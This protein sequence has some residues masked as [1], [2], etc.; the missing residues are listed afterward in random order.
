MESMRAVGYTLEAAIADLVDNS[1]T[2]GAER[3]DLHFS[4]EPVDY[5][6]ILDDG[7]GMSEDGAREAMRLAGKSSVAARDAHDLGRFGLGLKTASLSQCRDLVLVTKD[8]TG[9]V[10][11]FRWDLDHLANVGAWALM[12][13]DDHEISELPHVADLLEL[14]TGTLVVWR[15]LDQL[16]AQ[17]EPG[18]K[19][20][21]SAFAGVKQHLALVFHRF[22]AGEHGARFTIAVNHVELQRIDPFLA[23]H[24]ATQPG[25]PESFDV[26]GQTIRVQAFTL[27][28]IT[29]M[30]ARD[31]QRAQVAGRLRDSQ[32]F[33]IYRAKR[34]VIWG[35]W[36]RILPREELG[37]LARV[38]VDVPN[39]LDHLWAL[40]IKKS[41]AQ[42][43]PIVRQ[44]LKRIADRII[45]PSKRVHT[46]RGRPAPG[47][48]PITHA[49]QLISDG[50]EFRYEI[51][52]DHPVL[53]TL[54][55]RLE[56][57]DQATLS[58]LLRIIEDT[59]PTHDLYNRLGQDAVESTPAPD[60]HR[61][62]TVAVEVWA[63]F[64]KHRPDPDAF[65]AAMSTTEPFNQLEDPVTLLRQ[66]AEAS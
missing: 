35:T 29:K 58:A 41:A 54:A 33:Y 13:L 27:P 40:D 46:Y 4:S 49:W 32:G 19:G 43:P 26:E 66:A 57:S 44:R 20:L 21:D 5:V 65:I 28:M 3:V 22:L 1:I 56:P 39:S 15:N 53:A 16:R 47:Q 55:A 8:E 10:C 7:C 24:R 38:R 23:D 31:R 34:L 37:K 50:D 25:P 60:I 17:V 12:K 6:A 48:D 30:S 14:A 63:E 2:A 42:P 36:F 11:G 64:R 59:F 62:S 51:N 61:L 18:S 9:S 45:M 52:R